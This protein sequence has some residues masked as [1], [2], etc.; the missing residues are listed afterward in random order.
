MNCASNLRIFAREIKSQN[1]PIVNKH[2]QQKSKIDPNNKNYGAIITK[3]WRR[4]YP[5]Y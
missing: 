2:I 4:T 3:R 5:L 1:S